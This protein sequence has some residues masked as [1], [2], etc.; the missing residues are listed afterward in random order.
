VIKVADNTGSIRAAG[1]LESELRAVAFFGGGSGGHLY[2]GLALAECL[3]RFHPDCHLHFFR[4][5]RAIEDRVFGGVGFMESV[6]AMDLAA[7]TRHPMGT[8][9]F[10]RQAYRCAAE[11]RRDILRLRRQGTPIDVAVGLGGYSS[12]P[13]I[14]AARLT[15]VPL[16][17]MEQNVVPGKVNRLLGPLAR[18][19]TC[20]G[21]ESQSGFVPW[22]V[23]TRVTGNPLRQLVS[24]AAAWRATREPWERR[25]EILGD[26]VSGDNP[27]DRR[28]LL[29]MGGSQGAHAINRF[30]IDSLD[31]A[32]E[33]RDRVYCVHLTGTADKEEVE[34]AYRKSGWKARV[35]A[36]DDNLPMLMAG[37]DLVLARAGGTSL[38]ELTAI[39]VPSVLIPYSG[40]RDRH[41]FLNAELLESIGAARVLNSDKL[42][43]SDAMAVMAL[44]FEDQKLQAMAARAADH[45]R[46]DGAERVVRLMEELVVERRDGTPRVAEPRETER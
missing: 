44:L 24:D 16:V 32:G 4:T 46:L 28:L 33:Y 21:S 34:R 12:L 14:L 2:P 13:G 36:F 23:R 35:A 8:F 39:G 3:K 37:A 45:G 27:G 30:M 38:S 25:Q 9:R 43:S 10:A 5:G 1:Q 18:C 15:G 22:L 20:P 41:Q 17:L 11:I 19:V 29:V 7:P 42:T 6:S 31:A 40:H 26:A